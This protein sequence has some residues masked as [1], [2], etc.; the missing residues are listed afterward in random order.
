MHGQRLS[1]GRGPTDRPDGRAVDA[2]AL[3]FAIA[4]R[5]APEDEALA[6]RFEAWLAADMAHRAAWREVRSLMAL[7]DAIG[8]GR[9]AASPDP[10]PDAGFAPETGSASGRSGRPRAARWRGGRVSR[11]RRVTAGLC[12]AAVIMM[13]AVVI[14]TG[15]RGPEA[16]YATGMGERR[17]VSLPDGSRLDLSAESAVAL[18]FDAERRVVDLI[19]GAVFATVVPD[20]TRPFTIRAGALEGTAVGTA[21]E[22]RRLDDGARLAVAEGVVR[23]DRPGTSVSN[24]DTDPVPGTVRLVAGE[25]ARVDADA[26]RALARGRQSAASVA[27][28]RE[29]VLSVTDWPVADVVDAIRDQFPG[30]ILV[31]GSAA[32]G[33]HVTGVY[34]LSQPLR[35]L[36][37]VAHPHGFVVRPFGD[38]LI[39]L[40]PV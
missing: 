34:D 23:V 18:S 33:T 21:F 9:W 22:V 31:L 16:D 26:T 24:T 39:V 32:T 28:W 15:V 8:A 40:S 5:D 17:A 7:T 12:A 13:L 14:G 36:R 35:A 20:P 3:D 10:S 11:P 25:W 29:G 4:L 37:A 27:S 1:R 38:W 6:E 2:T 19:D 30:T